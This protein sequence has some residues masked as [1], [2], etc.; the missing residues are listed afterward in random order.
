MRIFLDQAIT[1]AIAL[2]VVSQL[3]PLDSSAQTWA[4]GDEASAAIAVDKSGAASDGTLYDEA[5][6][7]GTTDRAEAVPVVVEKVA[8]RVFSEKIRVQGTLESKYFAFVSPRIPGVIEEIFVDEG[9][10]VKAK[11]T[12]LFRTDALKLE[13]A[14]EVAKQNVNVTRCS[15]QVQEAGLLQVQVDLKKA[16]LDFK[17]FASLYER[18]VTNADQIETKKKGYDKSLAQLKY[19]E[20]LVALAKEEEKKAATA[21]TIAQKDL[22]DTVI[23]AP[24]SGKI[25]KRMVE[26]GAYGAPGVP[27]FRIDDVKRLEVSANL[28][29]ELYD[30]V[31]VGTTTVRLERTDGWMNL[32]V[33]YKSPTIDSSYR[34]F[35]IKCV[36]EGDQKF[37][38]PGALVSLEVIISSKK[39]LGV[40]SAAIERRASGPA[41]FTTDGEIARL[42]PISTGLESDGWTEIGDATEHPEKPITEGM[43]VIVKGQF[44]LDDGRPVMITNR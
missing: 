34:T 1:L 42:V 4:F 11:E 18:K 13:K 7:A 39:T 37:A 26:P 14:V 3:V 29:G 5:A 31:E 15:R 12:K 35:E 28:P 17:R 38:V 32:K 36:L 6:S 16:E 44:L 27:V 41:I 23:F 22:G 9:Y 2:V 43:S 8:T 10:E 19:S 33:S 40:S 25:S 30:R 24:L 20:S 21:L